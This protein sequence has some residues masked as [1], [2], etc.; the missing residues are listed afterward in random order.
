MKLAIVGSR[1]FDNY[2]LLEDYILENFE[3]EGLTIISGGAIGADNLAKT[4]AFANNVQYLEFPAD[5][6]T[7]GKSAGYKRN[8]QIVDACDSLVAFWD[9]VSKGTK[10]SID[11]AIKQDKLLKI[12]YF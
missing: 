3:S 2:D 9:G 11:L 10:H 4:F 8:V 12:I 1:D 7:H 6:R 5:W